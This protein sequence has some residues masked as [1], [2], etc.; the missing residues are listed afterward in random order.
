MVTPQVDA[1][2]RYKAQLAQTDNLDFLIVR[3]RL[4]V[5]LVG[6]W[7]RCGSP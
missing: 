3:T 4:Q 7:E 1:L 5:A 2:K 6:H